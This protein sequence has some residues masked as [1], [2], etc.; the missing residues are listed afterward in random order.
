MITWL[1]CMLIL[2]VI[3]MNWSNLKQRLNMIERRCLILMHD[4]N[5]D[6]YVVGN[7]FVADDYSGLSMFDSSSVYLEKVTPCCIED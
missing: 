6:L 3:I 4:N 5:A 7:L 1:P 2:P